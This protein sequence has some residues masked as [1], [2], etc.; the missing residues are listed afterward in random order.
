[1]PALPISPINSEQQSLLLQVAQQAIFVGLQQQR[2]WQ[3]SVQDYPKPLQDWA[4][5]FV[6]LTKGNELRGCIGTLEAYQAMV[7]DV[8]THAYDA[9][10]RDHRF[11]PL[12]QDELEDLKV[13]ISL[14]TPPEP[15]PLGLN[16]MQLMKQLV[17]LKDGLILKQGHLHSVFLP[18][19]WQQLPDPQEF[20]LH[21]KLKGG[22]SAKSPIEAIECSKFQVQE[23][24]GD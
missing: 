16:E 14:L 4:A 12:T 8:A 11:P 3:P 7:L 9:A 21:L 15:L 2:R 6:T 24:G 5:S 19:V 1:M 17:P 18:Q 10:F 23:F 22:W 20:L 13:H